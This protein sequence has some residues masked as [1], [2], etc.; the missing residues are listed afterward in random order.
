MAPLSHAARQLRRAPLFTL[1]ATSVLGLGLGAAL[2]VVVVADAVLLRP[3]PFADPDRLVNAWQTDLSRGG[4]TPLTVTGADFLDWQGETEVFE[5]LAAVSARGFTLRGEDRPE[6]VEGAV[7]SADFFALLGT[8]PLLGHTFAPGPP[9]PRAAVLSESLWRS[10]FG[11]E[12]GAIGRTL[13]LDGEPVQVIGVMPA[14]FRYPPSADIW[15]SARQ[16][17]PEHPTYPIDPDSDRTRHYLTVLARLR[18]GVSPA[19][20]QAALQLVQ[21][22]LEAQRAPD[23]QAIGAQLVP[24]H[25]QLFGKVRPAL[26]A[27]LGVAALLLLVGWANAA[28]LFLARAVAR[29]HEV[30]VRVALGAT[31]GALW[32][33]FFAEALLVSAAATA[34]GLV[35]GAWGAPLLV[36]ASPHATTL[37]APAL[38]GRVAAIALALC[39]ACAASLGLVTALQPA[40]VAGAVR[41]GGRT[42]TDGRRQ[43]RLRSAFLVFEVALSLVLL[44]AA[45]LLARSFHQVTSV[46]PGFH[47][48]GV[49]AA[50]LP[51]PKARY[52]D[53]AAQRRFA[54]ELLARFHADPLVDAAGLVSRLPLSPS[55]TVGELVIPGR[56][57]EAFPLDLRLATEGYFE[58]LRIPLREGRTFTGQDA[59]P[60]AVRAVIL[61][62]AAARRA[63]PGRSALGQRI[64]VWGEQ[65]PSEVV[66]VVGDVRHTGLD[67]EPRPEAWRPLGA[68]AWPNLALVVRGKVPA[69]ALVTS[70]RET[71]RS[72]DGE[73]PIVRPQPMTERVDASLSLRRFARELLSVMAVVA[74]LLALAG[75]YG[76][77]AYVVAQRTRE[78][79]VRLALGATPARLVRFVT[80]ETLLRVAAGCATGL[81]AGA[82][83]ARLLRGF[84]FGIV[85]VDPLTFALLPLVLAAAA[86]LATAMAAVRAARVDPAEAL[87]AP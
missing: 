68:V 45:G 71:V 14:A 40:S 36:A 63:F 81:A 70:V 75:I 22:R 34:L 55:N 4:G 18:P 54:A 41:G 47:A 7:V 31:R 12:P 57:S 58:A 35:L 60:T 59:E 80:G 32:R 13:S 56:E 74:A 19:Q 9:G 79:G 27:L 5:R 30:S 8:P 37:P 24:L 49:L 85:P 48:G 20:G 66:G 33:L 11:G 21:T 65:E 77:T 62:E 44:L 43:T 23:A 6:R 76:V 26:L 78:L 29:S 82:A 61:N 72:V 51:L 38:S 73:L 83:M 16:R 2:A 64:L 1:L 46:D 17:A 3:L 15:V 84:L 50:D 67:G 42:G 86:A 87:R 69:Q 52:P 39:L 25:E 28:H 10:R 53:A